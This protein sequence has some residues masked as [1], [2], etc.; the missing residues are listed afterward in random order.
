MAK[1]KVKKLKKKVLIHEMRIAQQGRELD[2]LR[3]RLAKLEHKQNPWNPYTIN[4]DANSDFASV[5]TD[6]VKRAAK[7]SMKDAARYL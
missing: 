6:L 4:F 1:D 7:R 5:A 3:A 2:E